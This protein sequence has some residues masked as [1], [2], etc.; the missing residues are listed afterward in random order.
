[1]SASDETL[2]A[3]AQTFPEF[4]ELLEH[5]VLTRRLA[6]LADGRQAWLKNVGAEGRIHGSMLHIGTPHSRAAHFRPNVAQVPNPKR[7]KPLAAECR[8]LFVA[9]D[10]WVFVSCDQAGLQDRAFAHYLWPHDGGNYAREFI[11]RGLDPHLATMRALRLVSEESPDKSKPT[12][13]I[14]RENAKSWRY[15]FLFGAGD[16]RLGA[17]LRNAVTAAFSVDPSCGALMSAI[18]KTEGRPD[19]ERL[20]KVG[21]AARDRFVAATPGLGALRNDLRARFKYDGW[22][23]G[24]DKRR[25]PIPRLHTSL[26]YTVTSAEA[27]ICKRWLVAAHA[28][29]RERFRY[30]WGADF[31]IVAWIHDELVACC[32]SE[33]ADEVGAILVKHAKAVQAPCKFRVPLDASYTIG[34]TWAGDKAVEVPQ[35]PMPVDAPP[36]GDRD[37]PGEGDEDVDYTGGDG[38]DVDPPWDDGPD[39]DDPPPRT[40]AKKS[41]AKARSKAVDSKTR[42]GT[43]T[44]PKAKPDPKPL[45]DWANAIPFDYTTVEGLAVLRHLR[46]PLLNPDGTPWIDASKDKQGKEFVWQHPDSKFLRNVS[47]VG[48]RLPKIVVKPY[49]RASW[50][51]RSGSLAMLLRG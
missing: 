26:N 46:V 23:P 44:G 4:G 24:L 41:K 36:A 27:I 37:N 18:F 15:A 19:A 25:V 33:I 6:A 34:R 39:D 20:Q 50:L 9:P 16:G 43:K 5:F 32:R 11:E 35:A 14:I 7:G 49:S 29:L 1:L 40:G 17:I 12:Y 51:P 31:V 22:I 3:A 47:S 48:P 28:E 13:S 2:E 21:L 45:L 10:D 30:G 38:G 42:S 8:S